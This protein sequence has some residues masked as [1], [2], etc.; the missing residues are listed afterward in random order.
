[1]REI[2]FRAWDLNQKELVYQAK[3]FPFTLITQYGLFRL[4]PHQRERNY[5]KIEGREYI[6]SQYTGLKD[7]NG[8]EIYEGDIVAY[9]TCEQGKESEFYEQK[10]QVIFYRGVF[11]IGSGHLYEWSHENGGLDKPLKWRHYIMYGSKDMYMLDF[12]I[13][14]I[15]NIYEH[16]KLL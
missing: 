13:E 12:D 5:Q 2:K 14:I 9:K 4:D 16:P 7:K 6:L 11:S 1:M 3:C 8:K 15:G 10:Q